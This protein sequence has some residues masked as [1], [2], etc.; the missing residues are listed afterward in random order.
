MHMH[1]PGGR[2]VGRGDGRGRELGGGED[3]ERKERELWVREGVV[4]V[5]YTVVNKL[6]L[7]I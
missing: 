5:E 2:G 4:Y 1:Q 6:R 7:Q 3:V